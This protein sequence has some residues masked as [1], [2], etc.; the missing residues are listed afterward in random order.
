MLVGVTRRKDDGVDD[1]LSLT[2]EQ[3]THTVVRSLL[4]KSASRNEG[5]LIEIYQF[6]KK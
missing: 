1:F 4:D 6:T 3:F 2:G 5:E